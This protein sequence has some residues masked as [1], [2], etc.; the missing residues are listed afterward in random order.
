MYVVFLVIR[1]LV[2]SAYISDLTIKIN[3]NYDF[4]EEYKK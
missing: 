2:S 4:K 3:N 1:F